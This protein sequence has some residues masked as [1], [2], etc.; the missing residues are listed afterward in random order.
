MIPARSLIGLA[1]LIGACVPPTAPPHLA[2]TPGPPVIIAGDRVT[3]G[4]LRVETPPGWR[5]ITG[6]ASAPFTLIFAAPDGCG[7]IILA[8]R[9]VE[10]PPTDCPETA[11]TDS[12]AVPLSAGRAYAAVRLADASSMPIWAAFRA[13]LVEVDPAYRDSVPP[14]SR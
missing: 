9:P 4:G 12:A 3:A 5:V 6:A 8:R 14:D 2:H 13:S 11:W 10:P 7:I 1:L